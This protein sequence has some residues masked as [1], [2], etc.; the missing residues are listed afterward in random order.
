M[1]YHTLTEPRRSHSNAIDPAGMNAEIR[2]PGAHRVRPSL[3]RPGITQECGHRSGHGWRSAK[4]RTQ[5][6]EVAAPF[7]GWHQ[8]HGEFA[9]YWEGLETPQCRSPR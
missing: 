9:T 6:T 1:R 4:P 7:P 2:P 3:M 8:I 5:I